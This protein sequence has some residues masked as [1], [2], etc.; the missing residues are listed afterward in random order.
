MQ[1]SFY[2]IILLLLFLGGSILSSEPIVVSPSSWDFG[3][4]SDK[5]TVEKAFEIVNNSEEKLTL[6]SMPTSCGCIV[7]KPT[8]SEVEP[9]GKAT[10]LVSFDPRGRKGKMRWDARISTGLTLQPKINIPLEVNILR[11]GIFSKSEIHLG[12]FPRNQISSRTQTIW[13]ANAKD[14]SFRIIEVAESK[15]ITVKYEKGVTDI[16]YPGEQTGYKLTISAKSDISLGRHEELLAIRTNSK[17]YNLKVTVF[18]LGD[19]AVFPDY[20]N[21]GLINRQGKKRKVV[22]YH[23]Q[24]HEFDITNVTLDIPE[25]KTEVRAITPKK[26]YNVW[27]EVPGQIADKTSFE[28]TLKI[29]TSSRD[30]P[31]IEIPL[32]GKFATKK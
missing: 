13:M 26:Y 28:G 30:Q 21:F 23:N 12:V 14:P 6:Q 7:H 15:N 2:K 25:I 29:Q 20:I 8:P 1:K 27:I 16:F 24:Y 5:N 3:D 4:I 10:F 22:M 31:L 17:I 19:I 11:E 9:G 32:R 18:I